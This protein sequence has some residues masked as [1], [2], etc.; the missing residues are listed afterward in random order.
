[1]T[2]E[3]TV[4]ASPDLQYRCRQGRPLKRGNSDGFIRRRTVLSG[5]GGASSDGASSC[6]MPMVLHQM[7]H[8]FFVGGDTSSDGATFCGAGGSSSDGTESC[9]VLVTLYQMAHRLVWCWRNF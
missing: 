1:M 7:A 8:H 9:L 5:V 3:Y 6:V 2:I 4:K